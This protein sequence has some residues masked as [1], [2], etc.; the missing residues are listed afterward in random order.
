MRLKDT[1]NRQQLYLSNTHEIQLQRLR[2]ERN[3]ESRRLDNLKQLLHAKLGAN[4]DR[5]RLQAA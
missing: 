3:T 1:A 4:P 5:R 2:H